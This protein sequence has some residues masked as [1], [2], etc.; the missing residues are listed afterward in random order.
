MGARERRLS[1]GEIADILGVDAAW[2]TARIDGGELRATHPYGSH[3]S[4]PMPERHR[5][6]EQEL[7][8]SSWGTPMG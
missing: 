4:R 7:R 2:V 8:S 3:P 1:T 6:S 5:I